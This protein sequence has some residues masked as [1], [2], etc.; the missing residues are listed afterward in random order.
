MMSGPEHNSK[1]VSTRDW[2]D[3][4]GQLSE[5]F[6]EIHPGGRQAT[7]GLIEMCGLDET[8][9]VLDV[10]C[11]SGATASRIAADYGSQVYGVDISEVMIANAKER[12]RRLGLLERLDFREADVLDLPFE[13]GWFDVVIVE[14]VLMPMPGDKRL[15]M[16]EMVR[17][18][19][20]G[21]K[22]GANEG[23]IKPESPPELLA[24]LAEHPA[25]YGHF[26]LETLRELF[27]DSGLE[28]LETR[29]AMAADSQ[30]L[31]S[32]I[33]LRSLPKFMVRVYP[34]LM[35]R[36]I[37]D[38]EIRAA[39]RIDSKLSK[40]GKEYMGYALIVGQKPAYQKD[41]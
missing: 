39:T 29:E 32:G 27:E 33:G 19:R 34:K 14:S 36:L 10:G 9:R 30:S 20:P 5:I 26:T 4:I 40:W 37:R 25:V 13:D 41:E 15:A 16:R 8:S 2:Y 18:V 3:F 12:A 7:L 17:V 11:G 6:P 38:R 23:T 24:I 21:G 22:V 28:V 31:L 35:F 1:P